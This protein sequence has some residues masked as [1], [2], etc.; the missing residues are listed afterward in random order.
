MTEVIDLQELLECLWAE[1]VDADLVADSESGLIYL[2]TYCF[3]NRTVVGPIWGET[4]D[5]F[6]DVGDI[7]AYERGT[8]GFT[9]MWTSDAVCATDLSDELVEVLSM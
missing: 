5:L 1:G 7:W 4:P 6:L 8:A 3:G 9:P 2:E